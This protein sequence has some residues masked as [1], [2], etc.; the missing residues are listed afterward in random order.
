[1]AKNRKTANVILKNLTKKAKIRLAVILPLIVVLIVISYGKTCGLPIADW[2]DIGRAMGLY[3]TKANVAT[4]ALPDAD[5]AVH[6]ID[7]G[8]ADAIYIDNG[9]FDMLIDAGD[10]ADSSLIQSYLE[11]CGANQLDLVIATHPDSDHIGAMADIIE[12]YEIEEF[13]QPQMEEQP[14]TNVYKNMQKALKQHNVQVI[15]PS[16]G[17]EYSSDGVDIG[18]LSPDGFY[19]S[20][21]DSSIVVKIT[22][23]STKFLFTG[24]ATKTAEKDML[25]SG[26]D[27]SADVLKV[28]HHG[29]K[30]STTEDFLAAVNPSLAVISVGPDKNNLPKNEVLQTLHNLNIP[31]YRTDLC[32]TVVVS[33]DG[34]NIALQTEKESSSAQ[35]ITFAK[36]AA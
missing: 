29:S 1:M 30:T 9:E 6:F 24:D 10:N 3:G 35:E 34:T 33:S 8:K 19:S 5:F 27:L 4:N 22:Y 7:V 25:K 15:N 11:S 28:G 17:Y 20:D 16:A 14:D 32:G 21:N 31:Y 26:V 18:V 12:N 23:G 2:N 36:K 13:W